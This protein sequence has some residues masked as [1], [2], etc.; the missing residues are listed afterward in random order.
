MNHLLDENLKIISTKL[1]SSLNDFQY[2]GN[3][4]YQNEPSE[5]S[6]NNLNMHG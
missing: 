1:R 2:R 4:T 3:S 5:Y 6:L